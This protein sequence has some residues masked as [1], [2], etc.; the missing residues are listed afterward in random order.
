MRRERRASPR[1]SRPTRLGEEL[2]RTPSL[3]DV[4]GSGGG[5]DSAGGGGAAAAA[6]GGGGGGGGAAAAAGTGGVEEA[7]E[8]ERESLKDVED[9][10]TRDEDERR[11]TSRRGAGGGGGGGDGG[12]GGAAAGGEEIDQRSAEDTPGCAVAVA[13]EPPFLHAALKTAHEHKSRKRVSIDAEPF[14]VVPRREGGKERVR[15][16]GR[17]EGERGGGRSTEEEGRGWEEEQGEEEEEE[18]MNPSPRETKGSGATRS[19]QGHAGDGDEGAGGGG[20]RRVRGEE[21]GGKSRGVSGVPPMMSAV[22]RSF[23]DMALLLRGQPPGRQ[24]GRIWREDMRRSSR[25]LALDIIDSMGDARG[26]DTGAAGGGD[27]PGMPGDRRTRRDVFDSHG[28]AGV[29]SRIQNSPEYSALMYAV[30]FFDASLPWFGDSVTIRYVTYSV[31]IM[32]CLEFLLKV[33]AFGLI[34]SATSFVRSHEDGVKI[35]RLVEPYLNSRWN[36]LDFLVLF[37]SLGNLFEALELQAVKEP[38][39]R[40][41]S[42][43]KEPVA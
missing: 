5:G 2:P 18:E 29:C 17:E 7:E 40:A 41:L 23:T 24:G 39:K 25:Q 33:A 20:G 3:C 15:E 36:R 14:D 37:S 28:F 13:H 34:G 1:Q 30:V 26:T 35:V 32:F 42:T 16:G 31:D 19:L 6:A 27:K 11:K 12:G 10:E 43:A 4:R 9:A 38:R 21:A 8:G 22:G